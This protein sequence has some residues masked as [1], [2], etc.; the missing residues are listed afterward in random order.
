MPEKMRRLRGQFGRLGPTA[1]LGVLLSIRLLNSLQAA[2][3]SDNGVHRVQ[4]MK[5]GGSKRILGV[6]SDKF[7]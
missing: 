1:V 2:I 6:P 7:V 4:L 3:I 5:E